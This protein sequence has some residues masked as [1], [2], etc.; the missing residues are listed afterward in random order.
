M[1]F[2]LIIC[3]DRQ[4][5]SKP[6]ATVFC[7]LWNEGVATLKSNNTP[8]VCHPK[9]SWG[10]AIEIKHSLKARTRL[11]RTSFILGSTSQILDHMP[12]KNLRGKF[13]QPSGHD[14]GQIDW[15]TKFESYQ[16]WMITHPKK[17]HQ[18]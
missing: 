14:A 8:S 4:L 17:N 3:I 16:R 5:F 7:H 18:R 2:N 1:L 12:L 6:D 9:K 13:T 11:P 10:R 15:N